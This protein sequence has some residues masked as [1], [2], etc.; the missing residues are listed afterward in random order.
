MVQK[1]VIDIL[2][3]IGGNSLIIFGLSGWLGKVWSNRFMEKEKSIYAK[4]LEA[5]KIKS[6]EDIAKFRTNSAESI[7]TLRSNYQKEIELLKN[8]FVQETESYKIKLK[9]SEFIFQKQFEALSDLITINR[10]LLGIYNFPDMEWEDACDE[11]V[12]QFQD[13][14]KNLLTFL[15]KHGAV[16][17]KD[18][19]DLVISCKNISG[20][21]KF[22]SNTDNLRIQASNLYDDIRKAEELMQNNFMSQAT[23]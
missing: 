2:L 10:N 18:V 14:E 12:N 7:E 1:E 23:I 17:P 15:S 9:K 22:E 16:L 4:E 6:N 11:I 19:N 13:I 21:N 8:T 3:S 20:S 5:I